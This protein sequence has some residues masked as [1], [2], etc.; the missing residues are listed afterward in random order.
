M[1]YSSLKDSF[2]TLQALCCS[3]RLSQ[4][5]L[6]LSRS[7]PALKCTVQMHQTEL[8]TQNYSFTHITHN[9]ISNNE[10]IVSPFVTEPHP[11]PFQKKI[12]SYVR[13][14]GFGLHG[15]KVWRRPCSRF[16]QTYLTI[17]SI[18]LDQFKTSLISFTTPEVKAF[19]ELSRFHH[20]GVLFLCSHELRD[21]LFSAFY[22][23]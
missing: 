6:E 14:L 9:D 11:A 22:R 18:L 13:I 17:F 19:L 21:R 15:E 1:R 5:S 8:P 10:R 3:L 12:E 7:G 20:L 23:F 2:E 16:Y 4:T